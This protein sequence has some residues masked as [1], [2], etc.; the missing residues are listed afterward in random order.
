MTGTCRRIICV[1]RFA[2]DLREHERAQDR[3]PATVPISRLV[4]VAD[5]AMPERSGGTAES[6]DEVTGT[7]VVPKPMPASASTATS[8]P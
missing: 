4:L 7:T 3:D 1:V 5:A 6:T 8:G 2:E